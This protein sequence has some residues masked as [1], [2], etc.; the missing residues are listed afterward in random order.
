MQDLQQE[1]NPIYDSISTK[2]I[3]LQQN[4]D[5][6]GLPVSFKSSR[7]LSLSIDPFYKFPI[8]SNRSSP[9]YLL[10]SQCFF[11]DQVKA[12]KFYEYL[13]CNSPFQQGKDRNLKDSKLLEKNNGKVPNNSLYSNSFDS[14]S[15]ATND[16]PFNLAEAFGNDHVSIN[17][18]NISS[19]LSLSLSPDKIENCLFQ[20][21]SQKNKS[22][23]SPRYEN[24]RFTSVSSINLS[25]AKDSLLSGAEQLLNFSEASGI[26]NE[27]K[28]LY[29]K[30]DDLPS[31]DEALLTVTKTDES[32]R[33]NPYLVEL[34]PETEEENSWVMYKSIE[35][36]QKAK[37]LQICTEEDNF[38]S[39]DD[40]GPLGVDTGRLFLNGE[41]A[42]KSKL[43]GGV[44][45]CRI[46]QKITPK[47]LIDDSDIILSTVPETQG[48]VDFPD[49]MSP[50]LKKIVILEGNSASAKIISA[51]AT[52]GFNSS[53]MVEFSSEE[54]LSKAYPLK[55][56]ASSNIWSG[57]L[58][59]NCLN[60]LT[61]IRIQ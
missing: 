32:L 61:K 6:N 28:R 7:F 56:D 42:S 41:T 11:P 55:K 44:S 40:E 57:L 54:H 2:K 58:S 26:E 8:F 30:N 47:I 46:I 1:L 35:A 19:A 5:Y 10:E 13:H 49:M 33:R 53:L 39:V 4:D 27:S 24:I 48:S 23:L 59:T 50:L 21:D 12:S 14:I 20:K 36:L 22:N 31:N 51:I 43:S 15:F 38:S 34:V 52:S 45:V 9:Y 17:T 37:I 29:Q 25:Q 18:S 16:K 3:L 60:I